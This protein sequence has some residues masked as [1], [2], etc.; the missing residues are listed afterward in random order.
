MSILR[1]LVL[2]VYIYKYIYIFIYI[3][4]DE[5]LRAGLDRAWIHIV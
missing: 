1:N 4:W 3:I 5:L 2:P